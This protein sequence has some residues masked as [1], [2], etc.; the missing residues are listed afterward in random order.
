MSIKNFENSFNN[1]HQRLGLAL[2]GGMWVQGIIGFLRPPRYVHVYTRIFMYITFSHLIPT[3]ICT[4]VMCVFMYVE[5]IKEE[6]HGSL[7]IGF[8]GQQYV[9]WVL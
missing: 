6:Q 7:Y 9:W 4:Y 3:F 8:L 1:N 2:Y 5:E